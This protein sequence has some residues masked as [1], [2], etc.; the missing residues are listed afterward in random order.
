MTFVV[1]ALFL[2]TMWLF[3]VWI[4]YQV[5]II[6]T[7]LIGSVV[8]LYCLPREHRAQVRKAINA[9]D[10]LRAI[11]NRSYRFSDQW[12]EMNQTDELQFRYAWSMVNG[13]SEI[14][15]GIILW[16]TR[17]YIWLIPNDIFYSDTDRESAFKL[18]ASR[19]TKRTISALG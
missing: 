7:Q 17:D 4:G 18:I 8:I 12:V 11:K 14:D 19:V 2:F 6:I 9:P 1:T 13:Y 15:Q 10:M 5:I 3:D 16:L